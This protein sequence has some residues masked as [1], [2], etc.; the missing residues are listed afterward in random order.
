M[1]AY[2]ELDCAFL[3]RIAPSAQG[4]DYLVLDLPPGTGDIHLRLSNG[5]RAFGRDRRNTPQN[6]AHRCSQSRYHV[7]KVNVACAGIIENMKLF[8]P[9]RRRNLSY[10]WR[11]RR[12]TRG[13]TTPR[14]IAWSH[15]ARYP[16]A[17]IRGT[18]GIPMWERSRVYRISR[19][20]KLPKIVVRLCRAQPSQSVIG[21]RELNKSGVA[22]R[23]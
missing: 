17:R 8:R 4:M 2:V 13:E 23:N 7:R 5:P 20:N 14:P 16:H 6:C 22:R 11:C 9:L 12:R 18:R 3:A 21:T 15:S 10:F 19:F 1:R